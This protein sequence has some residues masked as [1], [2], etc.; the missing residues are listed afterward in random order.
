MDLEF[1][2]RADFDFIKRA[3]PGVILYLLAWPVIFLS[4]GFYQSEPVASLFFGVMLSGVSMLRLLH[5]SLAKN[6]YDSH[7]RLWHGS[8][9]FLVVNHAIAWGIL[10]YAVN[11]LPEFAPIAGFVNIIVLGI[12]TA[13]IQSL[14]TKLNLARVYVSILLLPAIVGTLLSGENLQLCAIAVLFWLYLMIVGKR[15]Y[16]EYLRAFKIEK[17][18]HQKQA[19]LHHLNRT[20]PLTQVCNRREFD[21]QIK[22]CWQHAIDTRKSLTLMMLDIDHFKQ[23]NDSYGHPAGDLCLKHF[24]SN[25]DPLLRD[26]NARLYRYGGEEFSTIIL[27][28][29][30]SEVTKLAEDARKRIENTS[31]SDDNLNIEM[32][33]SI[34]VCTALPSNSVSDKSLSVEKLIESAD[35]ALYKAKQSGRNQVRNNTL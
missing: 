23:I 17:A 25:I 31:V 7:Y 16:R 13:S 22:A 30:Q 24:A 20:D 4:T 14:N 5:G 33:V 35:Q 9:L 2:R 27:S 1:R 18:L 6:Y 8:L 12:A 28:A 34:G 3:L 21:E 15:F 10:A 19:E 29:E 32:T 26:N 11:L